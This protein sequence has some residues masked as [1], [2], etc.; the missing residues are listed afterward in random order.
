MNIFK[1]STFLCK[2][3]AL[4]LAALFFFQSSGGMSVLAENSG[5]APTPAPANLTSLRFFLTPVGGSEVELLDNTHF[6]EAI[7]QDS[8]L[9]IRY[10]FD[11]PVDLANNPGFID[12]E[13]PL[14]NT[15][16]LNLDQI[17]GQLYPDPDNQHFTYE[18]N[19]TTKK[20]IVHFNPAK[21]PAEG[22]ADFIEL[23]AYF[24]LDQTLTTNQHTFVFPFSSTTD[25]KFT[26]RFLPRNRPR[27]VEKDGQFYSTVHGSRLT[28]DDLKVNPH[29]VK[30]T[31]DA[32]LQ[33]K[34]IPA[35]GAF[36][37][38][39][40]KAEQ[41]TLRPDTIAV[42]PLHISLGGTIT[43]TSPALTL[44]NDY[45]VI[46]DP[47]G[48][49]FKV[50]FKASQFEQIGGVDYLTKA[51]RIEYI[52]NIRPEVS[53]SNL[54]LTN[55]AELAGASAKK[56]LQIQ[57]KR[58]AQT[59]KKSGSY[60]IE[61]PA[62][63]HQPLLRW[64]VYLNLDQQPI[65]EISDVFPSNLMLRTPFP[66]IPAASGIT[67]PQEI[68][69]Q[70]LKPE[71]L[72]KA[73]P[74]DSDYETVNLHA[75]FQVN[76]GANDRLILTP[77]DPAN[78]PRDAYR[79]VFDT[80]IQPGPTDPPAG[81]GDYLNTID[82]TTHTGSA[83]STAHSNNAVVGP[84]QSQIS[85]WVSSSKVDYNQKK[86]SWV[87]S[88][89]PKAGSMNNIVISDTF[90]NKGLSLIPGS[91]EIK[92]GNTALIEN[93]DYILTNNGE[94]GFTV[95]FI[96]S[97][98][99]IQLPV[100][101]TY[102]T[103]FD[104][105]THTDG[106]KPREYKNAGSYQ[107]N[108]LAEKP[109]SPATFTVHPY[110][111]TNGG[112]E[113][114]P[115]WTAREMEWTVYANYNQESIPSL[116]VKD[117][118]GAGHELIA[119]SIKVYT[120]TLH[121][122]TGQ[123][124]LGGEVTG[125]P[126]YTLSEVTANGFTAVFAN[127]NQRYAIVYKTKMSD[128]GLS[129]DK[130][131]NTVYLDGTA[132]NQKAA[133]PNYDKFLGKVGKQQRTP[134][135]QLDWYIDWSVNINQSL[136]VIHD[137]VI[138][139]CLTAGQEYVPDS[140]RLYTVQPVKQPVSASEYNVII[141]P[142]DQITGEQSMEFHFKNPIDRE[143]L[144]EY[145]T[146]ITKEEAPFTMSNAVQLDG[147]NVQIINKQEQTSVMAVHATTTAGSNRPRSPYGSIS[148]LKKDKAS[149]LPLASIVFELW[150]DG[151]L[152]EIFPA[153]DADGKTKLTGLVPGHYL[154]KER[155]N[156][157]YVPLPDTAVEISAAALHLSLILEN[158][159][160]DPA[161]PYTPNTSEPKEPE[162][163]QP[164]NPPKEQ[165]K[166]TPKPE[167]PEQPSPNQPGNDVPPVPTTPP[168]PNEGDIE[169]PNDHIPQVVITPRNGRI[170][171]TGRH[172][173]YTP[174]DGFYGKDSFTV[175]VTTPTGEEYDE[176]IEIDIPIPEGIT[177]LPKTGG[178]PFV[179]YFLL[180]GACL[181]LAAVFK[182]K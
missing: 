179:F 170:E 130:Y 37:E 16:G 100:R 23:A 122:T 124:Q 101:I 54:T 148:I 159:P 112:K 12:W 149:S 17:A 6:P 8:V 9:K 133:F 79:L 134:A 95:Q 43:A 75:V 32:N 73:N 107:M 55:T 72:T 175:R 153:T 84:V 81:Q 44:G 98:S 52:T 70:R 56:D 132:V 177:T 104:R 68:W 60:S 36:V 160:A 151:T 62:S 127:A 158:T 172:W 21:V 176:E 152:V 33:Q 116:E 109:I 119:D 113:V 164:N 57:Y 42:Y 76:T 66:E 69:L 19:P 39:R 86:I 108:G 61:Y 50:E 167:T 161:A 173:K 67:A 65:K 11:T 105:H 106:S 31:V 102:D 41:L 154:L 59:P 121:N 141:K 114:K 155:P 103:T 46:T 123:P 166:D 145:S 77:L 140:F 90:P 120:Y 111:P 82:L 22:A 48:G 63:S 128:I 162:K 137:A 10:E 85:K 30:W 131:E 15:G 38:D 144:L 58:P 49:R 83:A 78:P 91:V 178:I 163:P 29:E 51:Y 118:I 89:E 53:G 168:G 45:D 129:V 5:G 181:G 96:N 147:E 4:L 40:F 138:K 80:T 71:A 88:I 169:I 182:K 74:T 14:S 143:Y 27:N 146:L 135:N 25:K 35:A 26:L 47:A 13:L 18:I 92:R 139:D 94:N 24:S 117:V 157:R 20:I 115:N 156:S 34:T 165:P 99:S 174:N 28:G 87:I 136:S 125:T 7:S 171:L 2:V 110:V 142:F 97:Y 93:T 1:S 150:K 126:A 180:G 64:S 3:M